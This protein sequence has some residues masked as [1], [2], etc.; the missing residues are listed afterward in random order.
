M[1]KSLSRQDVMSEGF[2]VCKAKTHVWAKGNHPNP[3][4]VAPSY[5]VAYMA[6]TNGIEQLTTDKGQLIIYDL[7]GRK[8]KVGVLRELSKGVYIVNGKKVMIHD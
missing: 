5:D 7:T 4:F 2:S 1:E 8:V 6:I 3:A